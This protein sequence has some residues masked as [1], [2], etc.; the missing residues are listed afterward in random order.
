MEMYLVIGLVCAIAGALVAQS[1]NRS[2]LVGGLA[3]LLLSVVGV[4]IVALLPKLEEKQAT[5]LLASQLGDQ[6]L[7]D[8]P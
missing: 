3:G 1:K 4:A 5:A 8:V 6:L 7:P 2:P